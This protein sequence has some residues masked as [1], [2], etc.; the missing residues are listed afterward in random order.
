MKVNHR[1]GSYEITRLGADEVYAR[2]R[3]QVVIT[4]AH[5]AESWPNLSDR[6]L[7]LPPGESAK[8]LSSYERV[9]DWLLDNGVSRKTTLYAVG[10]G[11]M[12]DLIG[13]VAATYMRGVPFVQVPTT[14]LAQ[15]DS[16][17]GGKVGIDHGKGKN[18]LGAFYP[19]EE[20]LLCGEFLAT[21]PQRQIRNGMGEVIKYGF[22]SHP[23]ILDL[24]KPETQPSEEVIDLCIQ[25]KIDVVEA[26]E[27]ETNGIRATLNFGHTVAHA[28]EACLNYEG[29][30]HGE[31]VA[32]GMLVETFI[33]VHL[34][35]CDD[36]VY[37]RLQAVL[38]S[39]KLPITHP[40]LS[41]PDL[42]VEAM[43]RDKKRTRTGLPFSFVTE[44]G[45]CKLYEG[46]DEVCV[47]ELI[48]KFQE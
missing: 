13:F 1:L 11:V 19:P 47:A 29:L 40:L 28:L 31:A 35:F 39:H 25:A 45:K 10:G 20:V 15:V 21:L 3:E 36:S 16:S 6:T 9:V 44:V 30:L 37:S 42:L 43:R 32:I 46:I 23:E 34:G 24:V 8:S 48:K 14:L 26:D 18:L 12:G 17:V 27:F 2:L 5:V 33:A 38:E 41:T 7:V 22:I 4:D